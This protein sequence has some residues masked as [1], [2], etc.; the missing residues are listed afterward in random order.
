MLNLKKWVFSFP[1]CNIV[2]GL[3]LVS[4]WRRNCAT[5]RKNRRE[6]H[7]SVYYAVLLEPAYC[8]SQVRMPGNKFPV[9]PCL[10]SSEFLCEPSDIHDACVVLLALPQRGGQHGVQFQVARLFPKREQAGAHG[11]HTGTLWD[12]LNSQHSSH[13]P[14][15][16]K[17]NREE[18]FTSP[19]PTPPC[20]L[21]RGIHTAYHKITAVPCRAGVNS[22]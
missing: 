21:R 12:Q 11:S 18:G 3:L 9:I 10:I 8:V 16:G 7:A 6:T 4:R 14:F 5:G 20:R 19:P 22:L 2:H 17:A 13:S 1:S 15:E